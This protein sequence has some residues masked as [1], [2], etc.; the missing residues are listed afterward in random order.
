MP[1]YHHSVNPHEGPVYEDY[2]VGL[3]FSSTCTIPSRPDE[4]FGSPSV[5]FGSKKAARAN[6][7]RLAVEHLIENGEL[8]P[9]GSP[10]KA[11]KKAKLGAA[12]RIQGKG[13]EVKR[14]STY[15]QKVNDAYGL[16]GLQ[17]PPQY[18]LT[19]A[20]DLTPSIFSGHASF[21]NEPGLPKEIGEARN[22]FGKKNAKEEI[23]MG[24]WEVLRKL[25]EKRGVAI[26]EIEGGAEDYE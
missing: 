18:V 23:A 15:T 14:G 24:V 25:A 8:N 19:A 3:S 13:L 21:P 20:S 16:L 1:E 26:S 4:P 7:A 9:D 11:R 22:V 17:T 12:V 2:S 10:A 5:P 6:A